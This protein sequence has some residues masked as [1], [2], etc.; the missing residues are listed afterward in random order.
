MDAAHDIAHQQL[1]LHQKDLSQE[2][3]IPSSEEAKQSSSNG[4]I[5]TQK[6]SFDAKEVA[7]QANDY[8]IE[9]K[10]SQ[11]PA[12]KRYIPLKFSDYRVFDGSSQGEIKKGNQEEEEEED[13]DSTFK[14]LRSIEKK[15]KKAPRR[16]GRPRKNV[17]AS[18][19]VQ[20]DVGSSDNQ[21]EEIDGK[22]AIIK[23]PAGFKCS[24]CG[25]VFTLR[26]NA[27]SHLITHTDR[28]PFICDFEGCGKK[29]R[30]KEALRRHQLSHL[31]IKMF[32]CNICRKKLSTN[33][34]LQEHMTV[35]S[36]EK[37]LT[38]PVC[39]RK[40][41]Q[42]TVMNR[43]IVTHST[44]KPYACTVC[45]KRFSM[46]VYVKSHM[47]THTGERPFTC[48]TCSKS[49]AHA[50]DLKRHKIIHTGEKPYA[51]SI[52]SMRYND[53]SSRK[54]HEREH[55]TG[56]QYLCTMCNQRFSRA[57]H[58]RA[59]L[60]KVHNMGS[61]GLYEVHSVEKET[62]DGWPP[63]SRQPKYVS[64]LPTSH[65]KLVA[66]KEQAEKHDEEAKGNLAQT[67]QLLV[68]SPDSSLNSDANASSYVKDS[69]Q[70]QEKVE[71]NVDNIELSVFDPALER[72]DMLQPGYTYKIIDHPNSSN[73]LE[74]RLEESD[75][76]KAENA[77]GFNLANA[78][79]ETSFTVIKE[80]GSDTLMVIQQEAGQNKTAAEIHEQQQ[81]K[82][83]SEPT[84]SSNHW[85]VCVGVDP[86]DIQSDSDQTQAI[87]DHDT[88]HEKVKADMK[89]CLGDSNLLDSGVYNVEEGSNPCLS[90]VTNES[91]EVNTKN[92]S[93][94]LMPMQ[95]ISED[96]LKYINH[97]DLTSQDY[98][99]WLST[100]TEQCKVL[101]LPL[102]K[103]MFQRISQVQK[104]ITDFMALPSG[105]I[106]D[107]NNFK[108]LMSI[109][110]DLSDIMSN[111]LMLMYQKLS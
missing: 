49:F 64:L 25:H 108:V 37:P 62:Q 36:G 106:T 14:P 45:G 67:M 72:L 47:K 107:K 98:Y 4:S 24:L 68:G 22:A 23:V 61:N 101:P 53:V 12:R 19:S 80:E 42:K 44:N 91:E 94:S 63:G 21:P 100:F 95:A 79:G 11:L 30:T 48:E 2:N 96:A 75:A 13:T 66:Q 31:G 70:I 77:A 40:F 69:S 84:N 50:S 51:C 59:H 55:Q 46:K 41:R 39:G 15:V 81:V 103:D 20:E 110:K 52:C 17:G 85:Q 87:L 97:P 71:K 54:R 10:F 1:C 33:I 102:Q 111:H 7:I 88:G 58:L 38:C 104:T 56:Q 93:A 92:I 26:G 5:G 60:V 74:F 73:I 9:R 3:S 78:P 16:R 82:T 32:E 65:F 83:A 89:A 29:L 76:V 27:K 57:G 8:E 109:T 35:H 6:S 99:N 86:S 28:R 18:V 90:D 34:S 105:V 43:H